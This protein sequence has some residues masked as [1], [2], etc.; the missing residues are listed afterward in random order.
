[1]EEQRQRGSLLDEALAD[2]RAAFV[3]ALTDGDAKAAS[4]V[5]AD[6]AR[7][8]APAAELLQGREAIEAFWSAGLDAGV[9]GVEL[10][11]LEVERDGRFAY[12]IG[13]YALRLKLAE[14]GTVVDRGKYVLVHERQEDGSWRWAVEM[15]NPDVPPATTDGR[16]NESEEK[17]C[18]S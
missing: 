12:E 16:R 8:L 14:G 17:R 2:S 15:F 9:S 3:A 6:D 18:S 1:M 4:A 7:L 11:A 13:R 10:E 5:Y